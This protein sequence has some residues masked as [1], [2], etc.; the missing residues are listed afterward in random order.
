[1]ER[2]EQSADR[3]TPAKHISAECARVTPNVDHNE[4]T[5]WRNISD[6]LLSQ[7][8]AQLAT[9][10]GYGC[11][12]TWHQ[13]ASITK[14][15][16]CCAQSENGYD[17]IFERHHLPDQLRLCTRESDACPGHTIDF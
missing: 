4:I 2:W 11:S 1:V 8:V 6:I 7:P 16:H 5:E 12:S 13:V 14:G 15:G 10:V 3:N 17:V 9:N